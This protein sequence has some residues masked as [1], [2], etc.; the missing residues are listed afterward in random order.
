VDYRIGE[1]VR[2]GR[3]RGLP[4]PLNSALWQMIHE[5]EDGKRAMLP[6]NLRELERIINP[7]NSR[8]DA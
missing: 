7:E 6:E 5:I 2:R 3:A 1:L 4:M 8:R